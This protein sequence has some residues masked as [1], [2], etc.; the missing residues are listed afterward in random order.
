MSITP[1]HETVPWGPQEVPQR[2]QRVHSL[3]QWVPQLSSASREQSPQ[4]PAVPKPP[5]DPVLLPSHASRSFEF[6][7]A[8][9]KGS[10]RPFA[11]PG[12]PASRTVLPPPG[13]PQELVP[14]SAEGVASLHASAIADLRERTGGPSHVSKV[15]R[16]QPSN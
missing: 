8:A 11:P 3:S 12:H 15:M 2:A 14:S 4:S 13:P 7:D 5:A 16:E 9:E 6:G 1:D 10:P